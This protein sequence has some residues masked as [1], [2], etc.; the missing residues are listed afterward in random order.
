[1]INKCI[2]ISDNFRFLKPLTRFTCDGLMSPDTVVPVPFQVPF[3]LKI[4]TWMAVVVTTYMSVHS[5]LPVT[6]HHFKLT[7]GN[8]AEQFFLKNLTHWPLFS[9]V[10]I[11]FQIGRFTP[12]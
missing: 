9:R 10:K 3:Q 11:F 7:L 4:L 2:P 6:R 12:L 5:T 1:M 8:G